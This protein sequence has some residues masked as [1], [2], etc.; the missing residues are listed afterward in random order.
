MRAA[1]DI[2]LRPQIDRI[3]RSDT[4]R[5]SDSLRRLLAY[6]GERALDGSGDGLKEYTI[7][8]AVFG[9]PESYDPQTDASV[10]VQVGKLRQRLEEY[11]R[12]EGQADAIIVELPKRHFTLRCH[13]REAAPAP[14][15]H[16]AAPGWGKAATALVVAALVG[17]AGW[18]LGRATAPP[19]AV[20][21]PSPELRAFWQPL[22][23]GPKP[24]LLCLGSPLFLRF[25]GARLRYSDSMESAKT[26][27]VVRKLR[28]VFGDADPL[29]AYEYTGVGEATAA[30]LLTRLFTGWGYNVD[31]RRDNAI[32]WDDIRSNNVIFLGSAKYIPQM[33]RFPVQLNFAVEGGG[34]KNLNPRPGE[35]ELYDKRRSSDSARELVEDYALITRLPGLDGRSTVVWLGGSA[36]WSTWGA[37]D[38]LVEPQHFRKV[39]GRMYDPHTGALPRYFELVVRVQFRAMVPVE[40]TYMTHRAIA[41]P[42]SAGQ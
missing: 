2:D 20:S 25:K 22:L 29:P 28:E 42:P 31:L 6:L 24:P 23:E 35:P 8:V 32:S 9:K 21:N 12:G 1:G 13:E 14:A 37:V 40:M 10:R 17:A 36:T 15:T 26:D 7:G 39:L 16:P 3:L 11:Y 19:P 38:C 34:V 18:L 5:S 33:Q 27:P 30:A 4:F 41:V